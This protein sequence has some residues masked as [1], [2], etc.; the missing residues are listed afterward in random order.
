MIAR[1]VAL[2]ILLQSCALPRVKVPPLL[3]L[4]LPRPKYHHK[5]PYPS[6]W[7]PHGV[8]SAMV[9]NISPPVKCVIEKN[10]KNKQVKNRPKILKLPL[11][12]FYQTC[13][14]HPPNPPAHYSPSQM[15]I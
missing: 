6:L 5:N 13:S 14:L 2:N 3:R 15:N 4:I 8:V 1:A 9:F 10:Q 11:V 7:Q 12:L